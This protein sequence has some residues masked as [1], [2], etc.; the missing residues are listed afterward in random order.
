[1]IGVAAASTEQRTAAEFFELF[2][3]PWTFANEGENYAVMVRTAPVAPGAGADLCLIFSA[4]LSEVDDGPVDVAPTGSGNATITYAGHKIPIY[5]L[6]AT[7]PSCPA[8]LAWDSASGKSAVH[9]WRVGPKTFVRVGYDLFSEI[10]HLL[11]VGQPAA[12][13]AV[14][15]LE[16]HIALLRDLITRA[17]VAVVEIPPVPADFEMIACLTHDL[18]HPAVRNHVFDHTMLGFLYRATFGSIARL[19]SGRM[20]VRDFARNWAAAA[21]LPLVYARILPDFW[22]RFDRYL[23][24]EAGL[25][26]TYFAIPRKG[27]PGRRR[28]GLA[29]GKRAGGYALS[30]I[31]PALKNISAAGNE[32][33]LHGIDAWLTADDARAERGQLAAVVDETSVGVR[34]HW[35]YF[36]EDSHAALDE[37]GFTYDSTVGYNQTVGYRA[38]TTQVYRPIGASRLLEL[39][40]HVMDTALFYPS[41]LALGED[42]AFR[43]VC[44]MMDSLAQ[45]GGALTINWHDRSLFPER[46]WNRFYARLLQEMKRRKAWF[47]TAADAVAWFGQRR[48]A[49]LACVHL[50]EDTL[51]VNGRVERSGGLPSLR[52]R[53]HRPCFRSPEEALAPGASASFL[54]VKFDK[55]MEH[56]IR[57]SP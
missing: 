40:L 38:G 15:T 26:A 32:V 1:M 56:R 42:E 10:E 6:L 7:F 54:D 18:D 31:Q 17:G 49:A 25:G 46:L 4:A 19:F 16:L 55:S 47:P 21:S 33:G 22:M 41:Y 12:Q 24:L 45:F 28:A 34:M 29:P 9:A 11:T 52:I 50:N 39:P 51:A 14:P 3:T 30:Q 20:T 23:E 2:K 37:A 8:T 44:R 48:M 57:I 36:D 5:G 27:D 43:L 35:L 53:V 13:A